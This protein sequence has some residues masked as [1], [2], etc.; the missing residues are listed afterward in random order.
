MS[1]K[2]SEPTPSKGMEIYYSPLVYV[3]V[4]A[5]FFLAS[6][7]VCFWVVAGLISGH[8]IAIVVGG[9]AAFGS[10]PLLL[11][12]LSAVVHP[13]RHKG[14]VLTLDESGV[15]DIRKKVSFIPWSDVASINLGIGETASF[16]CF[17]FR[18]ADRE[19]QD[20]RALGPLGTLLS[21]TRSLSDW[22]VTL[23][24]LACKKGDVLRAARR[25]QAQEVRRQVVSLNKG[26]DSGW[27][28]KL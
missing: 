9:V 18:V 15:T 7:W 11:S 27:S 5:L 25:L 1:P 13:W 24:M 2:R 8:V 20:L 22:N 12:L 21:R 14:P 19:R 4:T 28:G 16:L 6:C 23:R 17:E 26:R 3:P 10:A